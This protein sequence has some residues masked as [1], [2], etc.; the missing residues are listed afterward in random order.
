MPVLGAPPG[1]GSTA[2]LER[3]DL[4]AGRVSATPAQA[5]VGSTLTVNGTIRNRGVS[6]ARASHAGFFLSS[7]RKRGRADRR[8]GRLL[9]VPALKAGG[10]RRAK[11]A[12][13]IPTASTPGAFFILA[14]ADVRKQVRES[15]ERNNCAASRAPIQVTAAP[16]GGQEETPTTPGDGHE[17]TPITPGDG[18]DEPPTTSGDG[19]DPPAVPAAPTGLA[20]APV[21]ATRIDLT[22]AASSGAT[23]YRVLRST[24]PGAGYTEIATPTG[25]SYSDTGA[26]P[27]TT[28]YYVVRAVNAGGSSGDSAEA[29]ATTLPNAPA[30]PSSLTATAVSASQINLTWPA[31]AGATSY[32]VLR[33]TTSGTGYTEIATPTANSY[34]DTGGAMET[35]YYYVVRAVNAGG[36][37][38][39]STEASATTHC[40]CALTGDAGFGSAGN[41]GTVSGDSGAGTLTGSGSVCTIGHAV[42]RKVHVSETNDNNEY[43]SARFD[44]VSTGPGNGDVDMCVYRGD[45]TTEIGCSSLA[46]D[47]PETFSVRHDDTVFVDDSR[48]YYVRINLFSGA[49]RRWDL[50]VTGNVEVLAENDP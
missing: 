8:L 27:A 36:V 50:T 30:A 2:A 13:A 32:K 28:Y 17:E 10:K 15:S 39:N 4:T 47:F 38:G 33:S 22:W 5:I 41:L 49:S 21:S 23:S 6:R 16:G 25:N 46:A 19:S 37:S 43:L 9:K 26:G 34:S 40:A 14:C 31:A 29:S 3:P 35:T 7:D 48:D 20:A 24:T 12:L 1:G 44:L 42:W 45:G 11:T 18:Q